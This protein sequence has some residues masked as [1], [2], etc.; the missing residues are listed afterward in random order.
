MKI[1]LLGESSNV[2]THL[3][4]GLQ[5]IGHT[6]HLI[7]D[8]AGWK[9]YKSDVL[10]DRKSSKI[11]DKI[12]YFLK[13]MMLLP[14]WRNYDV[15]QINNPA[16]FLSLKIQKNYFIFNY[17]KRY[18]KKIF[19][20]AYGT[21]Y[22]WVRANIEEKN[23]RYSD[24]YDEKQSRTHENTQ[25]WINE[26]VCSDKKKYNVKMANQCN[27]I[28]PCLY[29][30]YTA[31][32][33]FYPPKTQFIPLPIN[34]ELLSKKIARQTFEKITFF[35]G[36]QKGRDK[37]KGTD[38]MFQALNKL[39]NKYPND[40]VIIKTE[41]V[42]YAEYERLLNSADVLLDQLYSYTPAMNALL[43]MAKGLVVVG[44]GEPEN[45]EILGEKKL[46]PIINVLPSEQDV[47]D[48]LEWLVLNKQEIPRLSKESIEY[49]KK[50]HD[51]IKVAKQYL[52]FWKR[53]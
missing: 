22:F 52:D 17:L 15:V 14:K 43:G 34:I 7:A 24:F 39:K 6:V 36:V 12:R 33:L 35:I 5:K 4:E 21:D 10:L 50:H 41:S 13:I 26:W 47:F 45:Y 23:L 37:E 29:E 49:V 19:L 53:S 9:M 38:I 20:A 18:N 51:H 3:K 1:L 27:G 2:H 16:S 31:Y 42:P 25:K 40:V 11:K 44:G 28:I 46:R 48:K 30:Y 32:A 8:V